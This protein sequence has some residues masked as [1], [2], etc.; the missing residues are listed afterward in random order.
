[1]YSIKDESGL[2]FELNKVCYI[3]AL[4]I[5]EVLH[6]PIKPYLPKSCLMLQKDILYINSLGF[7]ILAA[8]DRS[9]RISLFL[10]RQ[11]ILDAFR[12]WSGSPVK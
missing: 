6:S 5:L 4:S 12:F 9:G 11:I 3:L 7:L 2:W 1:M 8:H 10:V